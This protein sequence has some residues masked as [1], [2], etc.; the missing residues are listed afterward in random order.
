VHEIIVC[1]G[2]V[3]DIYHVDGIALAPKYR[4]LPHFLQYKRGFSI[5]NG[6]ICVWI[7]LLGIYFTNPCIANT[8]SISSSMFIFQFNLIVINNNI[9]IQRTEIFLK[10]NEFLLENCKDFREFM[11]DAKT[12]QKKT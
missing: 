1:A 9:N 8:H 3:Q 11:Q 12:Q 5:A 4:I 2:I 10:S 6:I 7:I